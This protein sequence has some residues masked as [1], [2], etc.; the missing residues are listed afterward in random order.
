MNQAGY[1]K[2]LTECG[3]GTAALR[4]EHYA[5]EDSL[6]ALSEAMITGASA[7]QLAKVVSIALEF[8]ET[9]FRD[10][11]ELLRASNYPEIEKHARAHKRMLERL[12]AIQC[13][14]SA[15]GTDAAFSAL[16]L[17]DRFHEHVAL[18]DAPA[19]EHLLHSSKS[20]AQLERERIA[21]ESV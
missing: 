10:E 8:Q 18:Q 21:R 16:A 4:S 2:V 14:V 1:I 15:R 7:E 19:H 17:L 20:E 9:H 3:A 11:E 5:I 13:D 12:R 6:N